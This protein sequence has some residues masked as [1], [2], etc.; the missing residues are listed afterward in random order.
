MMQTNQKKI[1]IVDD[2]VENLQ[3]AMSYIIGDS[4]PYAMLAAQ[5]GKIALRIAQQEKPDIIIMDWEMP[6]MNGI[7]CI[8]EL[9]KNP[10]TT[11]IPVII[12][13][14][15]RL[16][17]DD[18]NIAFH[19]GAS[20]FIRKPLEK[21]EF[22][23]RINSHLKQAELLNKISQQSVIINEAETKRLNENIELLEAVNCEN[24]ETIS[25]FDNI[26]ADISTRL[27]NLN[28]KND[29]IEKIISAIEMLR[30]KSSVSENTNFNVEKNY[31][32]QLLQKHPNLT[33]QEIQLC[34]FIKKDVQTKEIAEITFREP[35]S[36]KVAR[37]RL[38]KK[39]GLEEQDNLYAFL[40][41]I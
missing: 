8:I 18:L 24:S 39:L 41:S 13:T 40:N 16:T 27:R 36:V 2:T 28:L 38:R 32:Y 25:F 33:P 11:N 7:D 31:I 12:S 10:E 17:P 5:N 23:A 20:D 3:I 37:S 1:L 26:L 29:E 22:L 9:K 4:V 30:K 15:I 21:T 34:V 14:G 19:A 35:A 6:V